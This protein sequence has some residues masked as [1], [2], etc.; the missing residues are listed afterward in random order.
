MTAHETTDQESDSE[1][2]FP[3][4]SVPDQKPGSRANRRAYA[5]RAADRGESDLPVEWLGFPDRRSG[6]DRRIFDRLSARDAADHGVLVLERPVGSSARSSSEIELLSA[7]GRCGSVASTAAAA[8]HLALPIDAVGGI[9]AWRDQTGWHWRDVTV[10]A[11][12][13][14]IDEIVELVRRG[15]REDDQLLELSGD[16]LSWLKILRSGTRR[17]VF[18]SDLLFDLPPIVV[19]LSVSDELVVGVCRRSLAG[20]RFEAPAVVVVGDETALLDGHAGAWTIRDVT[21][22]SESVRDDVWDIERLAAEIAIGL[23]AA[24]IE[25][26]ELGQRIEGALDVEYLA[27]LDD[28]WEVVVPATLGHGGE[29]VGLGLDEI[30]E[31]PDADVPEGFRHLG[32]VAGEDAVA[33]EHEETGLRALVRRYG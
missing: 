14:P 29:L 3:A 1:G 16:P 20:A 25:T 4:R 10:P 5:R 22:T 23:G 26:V 7:L 8:L 18:G 19:D 6:F 17:I 9:D 28:G 32:R 31:G 27:S 13:D 15:Q 12:G 30:D 2:A 21:A 24:S 33:A 11:F